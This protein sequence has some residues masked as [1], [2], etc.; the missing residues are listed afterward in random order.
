LGVPVQ[1]E[2]DSADADCTHALAFD[3]DG[4]AIGTARLLPDGRIGRLAVRQA[5]R[6]Q[7]VGSALLL[8]L[9]E[10]AARDGLPRVYLH[11]QRQAC[12]FYA[13][14]GFQPEGPEF[15]EAGIAHQTMVLSLELGAL[16]S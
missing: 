1:L 13:R 4:Q 2:M 3:H 7:G 11:A 14:H 10:Q 8:A 15:L 12:A 9:L 6:G 5:N 16:G